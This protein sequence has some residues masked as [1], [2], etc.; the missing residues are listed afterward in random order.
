MRERSK[1]V[2]AKNGRRGA[3]NMELAYTRTGEY[4][5][6][7]VALDGQPDRPLGRY[8]LMRKEYLRQNR[9]VLWARLCTSGELFPHCREIEDA[10]NSRLEAVL[11]ALAEASGA[12]EDL[13]ARAPMRWSAL[14]D[15]CKAQAEEAVLRE[16][17]YT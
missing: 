9:P 14:M 13:K 11:S 10:A 8:G 12:T 16:L 1:T 2:N 5:I 4:L 15:A 3:E 6:P 7:N 17:V